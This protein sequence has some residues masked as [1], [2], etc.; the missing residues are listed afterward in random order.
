MELGANTRFGTTA[1]AWGVPLAVE[2]AALL[3]SVVLAWGIGA[4][5]LGR[6]L[7]LA[8]TLR[9]AEMVSDV[10]I[11]RMLHVSP[12]RR[13]AD[14]LAAL[15]GANQLRGLA[16]AGMMLVLALPMAASFADGASAATFAALALVPVIRGSLHLDYRRA[17]AERRFWPLAVVEGV[18]ALV[19]LA[20]L[21]LMVG[22]LGD[23]RAIIGLMLVQ[24]LAQ[25]MFSHV[26]AE[27]RYGLRFDPVVVAQ[28]WRFGA[29]LV[30]NAGLMFLSVQADRLIVAGYYGWAEVAAYGVAFQLASLPAQIAGRAAASSLT[31]ALAGPESTHVFRKAT[32][33]F[34]VMAVVFALCFAVMAPWAIALVYGPSLEPSALL[35]LGLGLAAGLRILRT[36]LSVRA[37][38]LGRTADPA[39][40]NLWRAAALAPAL[41]VAAFGLPLF[42]I[43]LAA[44]GG[45]AAAAW[46]ALRLLGAHTTPSLHPC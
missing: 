8:L 3:R 7:V 1:L 12:R 17:E 32:V 31:T 36:P 23:E 22:L 27:Q 18:S 26:V 13:E 25:V 2:V 15:H 6:A 9:L 21:P 45:E 20:A 39:R 46:R 16:I 30:L 43:A 40:A 37:V 34:T 38:A 28:L 29:P 10:G 35:A 42:T 4:E 24:V 11:E 5:N 14:F 41:G 33:Q 44:V 19:M